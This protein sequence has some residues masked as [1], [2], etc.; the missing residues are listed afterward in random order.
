[1]FPVDTIKTNMQVAP[2]SSSQ[3]PANL[4]QVTRALVQER[5]VLRL[6][7]GVTAVVIGAIPSHAVNYAAYEFFKRKF[8]GDQPGHH[9]LANAVAGSLATCAHDAVITPLD[10]VKQRL[11]VV[12][13]RYSGVLHC[14]KAILREEGIGAFYAS[15]PTTVLMN[16]PFMAV[17]F[18]G[19]ESFKLLLTGAD[20][21]DEH[22]VAEELIAG[23]LAGACAGLVSTPLDV[24][25]T[26]IQTQMGGDRVRAKRALVVV[27]ELW[28][29][30][31][32]RGFTRG[33]SARVLY[34]MPSA[35]I[36]WTTY[37]TMKRLLKDAW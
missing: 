4:L 6:Y 33:A 37:E 11:Q 16:V 3:S 14:V 13:S 27:K 17:H 36:C 20:R 31:G 29:A 8:G 35:A 28:R 18:A 30:E 24:V 15:Y 5:G 34:F 10:V 7:R 21:Q 19:Y 23:G 9:V 26:R 25:K 32:M 12:N 1:M 22:G 2:S